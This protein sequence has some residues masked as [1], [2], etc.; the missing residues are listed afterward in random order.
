MDENS[1]GLYLIYPHPVQV[2][3]VGSGQV[4]RES[5]TGINPGFLS[6]GPVPTGYGILV[7]LRSVFGCKL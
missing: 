2:K 4:S 3:R 1:L 6:L 7:S 5:G